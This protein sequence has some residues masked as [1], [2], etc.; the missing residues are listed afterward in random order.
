MIVGI[1]AF[2]SMLFF[3]GGGEVFYVDKLE[4]GIKKYVVEKER[5]KEILGDLKNTKT[6]FKDFEKERDKDF[7]QFL[8]LYGDMGTTR[9][10]LDSFFSELQQNRKDFQ[11]TIIDQR[12]LIFAK[13][14]SLEWNQILE[15]SET[16]AEKRIEKLKKKEGKGKEGFVKTKAQIERSEISMDQKASLIEALEDI[17]G[18]AKDLESSLL[19][20]NSSHNSILAD[21]DS[22]KEQLKQIIEEDD[23]QRKPLL[24]SL[25]DFHSLARENCPD[26]E[27]EKIIKAFTKEIQ[28]TSR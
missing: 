13:I 18:L 11:N 1:V 12:L 20:I 2:I 26:T 27:G 22:G 3:G 16:A 9:E 25:I 7:K 4:K 14:E 23:T 5:K 10:G 8:N 24:K 19:S 6:L 28:A 17:E 15:S 21:K